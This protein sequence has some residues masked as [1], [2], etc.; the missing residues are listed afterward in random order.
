MS[1][2]LT[3]SL[4]TPSRDS[5]SL[6]SILAVISTRCLCFADPISVPTAKPVCIVKLLDNLTYAI[7]HGCIQS[8]CVDYS[9]V[10]YSAD[11][12]ITHGPRDVPSLHRTSTLP[13][14]EFSTS[15]HTCLLA[16]RTLRAK[17]KPSFSVV[18]TSLKSPARLTCAR[19]GRAR[20]R[21]TKSRLWRICS[22]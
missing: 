1:Y 4:G 8:T 12:S 20:P 17:T 10:R 2:V 6:H 16:S 15:S 5:L 14:D 3:R 9:F 22:R 13:A 11:T 21:S 19:A 18:H 7:V